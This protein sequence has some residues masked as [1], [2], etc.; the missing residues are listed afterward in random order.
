MDQ[1]DVKMDSVFQDLDLVGFCPFRTAADWAQFRRPWLGQLTAVSCFRTSAPDIHHIHR[2]S[3]VMLPVGSSMCLTNEM[4]R[5][6]ATLMEPGLLPLFTSVWLTFIIHAP[7]MVGNPNVITEVCS[8][9]RTHSQGD[10]TNTRALGT[11]QQ[12]THEP[13][14]AS[15]TLP[16]QD[17]RLLFQ[18]TPAGR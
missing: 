4:T 14:I 15:T 18:N 13:M 8:L 2:H 12:T 17:F 7:L 1:L 11:N 10:N 9:S 5:H 6:V 16:S 3:I